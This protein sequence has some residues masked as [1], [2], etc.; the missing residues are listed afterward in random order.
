[1]LAHVSALAP[2]NRPVLIIGER[3]TRKQGGTCDEGGST[4]ENLFHKHVSYSKL[5][6]D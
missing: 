4:E 2:L 5:L 3:G 6:L 1:M